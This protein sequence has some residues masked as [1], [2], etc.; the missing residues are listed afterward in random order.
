[1]QQ[2][3]LLSGFGG[4]GKSTVGNLL[5]EGLPSVALVEADELFHIKPF[6]IGEKMGRIKLKNS[7]D[8]MS[9][10]LEEGYEWVIC[11]GLVWVQ[12]E[13]DAVLD[14]FPAD[15]YKHFLFW[16]Q[17][18]RNTRFQ[19][20]LERSEPGDTR[21]WLE[22]VEETMDNPWPF[23]MPVGQTRE[24]DRTHKSAADVAREIL[25]LIGVRSQQS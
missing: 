9:N 24:I 16:L 4:T 7:L 19:R 15:N 18:D 17:A 3:L 13:L 23:R 25:K 12:A 6:E 1:M 10:F 14:A 2:I 21:E 11:I 8:V 22:H 20:V 5:Y